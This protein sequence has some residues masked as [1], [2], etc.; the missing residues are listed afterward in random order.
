MKLNGKDALITGAAAL[1]T[2]VLHAFDA[3]TVGYLE[4]AR[5]LRAG[6]GQR[7]PAGNQAL[8]DDQ[9]APALPFFCSTALIACESPF[10]V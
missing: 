6:R 10:V 9:P 7:R 4:R 1:R 5:A 2:R 3:V 8:P